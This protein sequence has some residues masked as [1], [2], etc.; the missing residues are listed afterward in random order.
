MGNYFSSDGLP[1]KLN[2]V[3]EDTFVHFTLSQRWPKTIGT[4]VDH[5]HNKHGALGAD[6]DVKAVISELSEIS[7]HI[8]TDAPLKDID[9]TSYSHEMWNKLL[10][11]MREKDGHDAV[12]WFKADWLF[13]ECYM[14]RRIV[15][16]TAKTKYLKN[17]DFFRD[18][19][20]KGFNDQCA[21]LFPAF[22]VIHQSKINDFRDQVRDGI[23]YMLSVA[24]NFTVEEKR[25]TVEV[26]LKMCLWGNRCDLSLSCGGSTQ[27]AQAPIEAARSLD[28]F[29]LCNDL[30]VAI[31]NYFMKMQ[32]RRGKREF[33]IVLDNAGPELMG[34]LIF[35]E[36]LLHSKLVDREYPYF[37]SDVTGGDFEWTLTELKKLGDV[38][39][40][41]YEKLTVRV[42]KVKTPHKL[43]SVRGQLLFRDHRFWTYPQPYCEMYLV[44]PELYYELS[45][46][47]LIMFKGDLNYRKLTALCGF[48][49]APV[50]ALRT[51]KSETVAGL[52]K[53]VAERMMH[54]PDQKWMTTGEYG[55]AELA[56]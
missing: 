48:L 41:M 28:E 38:F 55:I 3:K 31:D 52:P 21:S 6:L 44:A 11:Q 54:E 47:S 35:S 24:D 19:K 17:Y 9:D 18:Q 45:A 20:I 56:F 14:Y 27:L 37:V 51:L 50:L 13:T 30:G 53:D 16:A 15:G 39:R 7:Y 25:E 23:R 49:P 1:P 40:T 10:S 32:K 5:F 34:D 26:L 36:Y 8:V 43:F 12:T 29:I 4:T 22:K 46:A 33:H 2:G 42:K